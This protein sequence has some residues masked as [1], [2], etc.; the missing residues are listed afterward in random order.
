MIER[1]GDTRIFLAVYHPGSATTPLTP[2]ARRQFADYV[3]A[4]MRDTPE[5]RDVIIGNEPN[6]NRFWMPQFDAAGEDVAA[7]AYLALLIEVYDALKQADP[8]LRVWGGALAPRGIDRP[9]TGRDTHSPTTFIR[10]LGAAYR[11]SGLAKPPLDGFAFHPYP[12]SSSV[13]PDRPT[14]AASTSILMADYEEKLRP[15]LDEAFGPGLPVLY[16]ELGVET[17]IPP[18]QGVG[19]RGRGAG[20]AGRRG[21]PGRLLPARDRARRLPGERRRPAALSL[22]RR[23]CA[24]RIP[25]RRLLRRR[26]REVQ[27]GARARRRGTY[28]MP[29]S[30]DSQ[31]GQ[32]V[33]YTFF[34]TDPAWRRLP[35]EERTAMKDA[36]AEVVE[37]WSEQFEHLRAYSTAGVRPDVDFF[38]WKIT[39]RYADLGELGA[40]LNG[41]PLAGWLETPYNYLATTKASAYTQ[42]RRPRK[43]IPKGSPYLVV[44]PFVKVRPWYALSLEDRQRAMDE[45][46]R[47]GREFE[48]IHNHTTYSFG[49]D[50]QEFMTAFECDEPS[51]FMHLMLTLRESEASAYTERDTPIFVGEGMTI[52]AALDALDGASAQVRA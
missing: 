10:D 15:L 16:S 51:D 34:K 43:I 22:P 48:T 17:R 32:Y 18:R 49:I 52:R 21:D 4:I 27:P 20:S 29:V 40:A 12:A 39:E 44:Y 5:I 36:F 28:D 8:E 2:E 11:A 25:V 41:T 6:L 45:H 24:G 14:A 38:L 35:L 37:S 1:A 3:T 13:P 23:A 33:A 19:L 31:G 46:I 50:D 9:G 47:V 30:S 7:P 42:A 26:H